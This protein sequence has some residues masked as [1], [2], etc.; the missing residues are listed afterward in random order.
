MVSGEP[1]I[2]PS[3]LAASQTALKPPHA[4][5]FSVKYKDDPNFWTHSLL[6]EGSGKDEHWVLLGL[7]RRDSASSTAQATVQVMTVATG[8]PRFC[9]VVFNDD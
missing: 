9:F 5:K 1:G 8:A 4:A 2:S 7:L 6:R 3:I